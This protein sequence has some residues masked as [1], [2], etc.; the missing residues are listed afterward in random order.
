VLAVSDT[1]YVGERELWRQRHVNGDE[2]MVGLFFLDEFLMLPAEPL[3]CA[4]T[5]TVRMVPVLLTAMQLL[6]DYSLL[7]GR[8]P[9]EE[10]EDVNLLLSSTSAQV[11]L[12]SSPAA[13]R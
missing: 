1:S 7:S 5:S 6:S 4:A 10:P 2:M 9:T 11:V 13:V 12:H 3:L 8:L